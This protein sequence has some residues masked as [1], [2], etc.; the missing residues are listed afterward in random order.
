[1]DEMWVDVLVV[2][3]VAFVDVMS[4]VVLV[5]LMVDPSDD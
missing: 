2:M 3:W 4:V 1:M 5:V